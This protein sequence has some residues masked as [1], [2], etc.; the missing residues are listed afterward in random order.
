MT[1]GVLPRLMPERVLL[2]EGRHPLRLAPSTQALALALMLGLAL[3]AA[4]SLG[5]ATLRAVGLGGESVETALLR[6][7]YEARILRL[8]E[9][10]DAAAAAARAERV[11]AEAV[12]AQVSAHQSALLETA[13]QTRDLGATLVAVRG[14]LAAAAEARGAA[15]REAA[16]LRAEIAGLSGDLDRS[17]GSA[18]DLGGTVE[19]LTRALS[20][21]VRRSAAAEAEAG[22]LADRVAEME[23]AQARTADRQTRLMA[24]LEEAVG[25][26]LGGVEGML[27]RTG[28][29]LDR[30]LDEVRRT[31]DG[32]G[33]PFLSARALPQD[34]GDA[35]MEALMGDLERLHLLRLATAKLPLAQPVRSGYR[36]TSGFGTRQ[37]PRN[38]RM[39]LHE[40][41]D[42]AGD[43]GTPILAAGDGEVVFAGRDGGYG[44]MVKIRHAFGIET[45]YAHLSAIRVKLGSRV[46][47]GD[48]IGDMGNTG[49]S[50]G[51]H[52]HYEVR[53]NGN[54][55]NP[56]TYLKAASDVF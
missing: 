22:A 2:T 21:Q 39:R 40:G 38:R 27:R 41:I 46:A 48:R 7:A 12:L 43:R 13:R 44:L 33:G 25:V 42:L 50:T 28:L 56:M 49:R 5:N 37:D 16:R 4:M 10:R 15:E 31:Y 1:G 3:W 45:G 54:P 53:I 55:V 20:E 30:L 52:L 47:Q 29:D 24:R 11:R 6:E 26:G 14:Q 19:P 23:L 35:Q 51:T 36:F 9:E 32:A 34:A 8:A 17:Q 18:S